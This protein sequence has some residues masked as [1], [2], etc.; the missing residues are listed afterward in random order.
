MYKVG[1]RWYSDFTHKKQR[2]RKSWGVVTKTFAKNEEAK[3]KRDIREG[4]HFKAKPL[5]FEVFAERYLD[6][7]KTN[8]KP[9]AARR[10]GSSI[11]MLKP[12]FSGKLLNQITS[13]DVERYKKARKDSG[14]A[15]ATINRDLDCINNMMEKAVEWGCLSVNP[16]SV[17]KLK[18][19][20]EKMW[21]L[22]PEEEAALLAK[23]VKSPQRK[24]Y[25]S[26]LVLFALNTGMR[27]DEIFKLK[28]VNIHSR[29]KYIY[30]VD[31]KTRKNRNVPIN[32]TVA[33]VIRRQLKGNDSEYLFCNK[34]GNR[35]TVL[36]NAFWTAVENA[37][38]VRWEGK[39]KIRFR[40]HDLRHTFGSRLGMRGG[41]LKS[42]MEIMGHTT[43][44]VAMR[45]QHPAP[46][47]K[48][49]MVRLLDEVPPKS[50]R[51]KKEGLKT[52]K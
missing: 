38:L 40:F 39:K 15:A 14:R 34:K 11:E 30:V 48:L 43:A 28:K 50:P 47:H 16:L 33:Q 17:K 12:H 46:E 4:K 21:A 22:T 13:F 25:L 20:N 26:D 24:K 9:S 8:K 3:W 29:K 2:Y 37:G 45:Y 19:D 1:D 5:R 41:D 31:T 23:C 32:N 6:Y 35:L 36:T 49:S 10:N 44:R 7:A 27:L 18:E 52:V 51:A 42:I